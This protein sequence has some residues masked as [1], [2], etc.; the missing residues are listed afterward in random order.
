MLKIGAVL[1]IPNE[2]QRDELLEPRA[3]GAC[4]PTASLVAWTSGEET[5]LRENLREEGLDIDVEH[6]APP[7]SKEWIDGSSIFA[8]E[9]ALVLA[10]SGEVDHVGLAFLIKVAP[11]DVVVVTRD[12]Q[13]VLDLNQEREDLRENLL[14]VRALHLQGLLG[15]VGRVVVL[16]E[17]G[18]VVWEAT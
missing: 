18:G 7:L 4:P 6:D 8:S 10:W 5:E 11:V 9:E 3:C 14:A 16:S 1:L 2:D 15:S 12:V 13:W 17:A